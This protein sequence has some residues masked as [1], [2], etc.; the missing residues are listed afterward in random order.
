MFYDRVIDTLPVVNLHATVKAL[1]GI[2]IF[3]D[4]KKS[5]AR[6]HD[7]AEDPTITVKG[8]KSLR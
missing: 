5:S 1:S 7:R 6:K 4:V 8:A 3:V 2:L